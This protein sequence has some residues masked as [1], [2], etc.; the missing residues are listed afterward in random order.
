MPMNVFEDNDRIIDQGAD[1]QGEAAERHDID[2]LTSKGEEDYRAHDG[3]GNRERDDEHGTDTPQ[4]QQDHYTSQPTA[5]YHFV[6]ERPD[7]I[8]DVKR[9]VED[10]LDLDAVR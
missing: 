6:F 2:G 5:E 10:Q 9:L 1:G 7:R 4:K 3:E 8:A